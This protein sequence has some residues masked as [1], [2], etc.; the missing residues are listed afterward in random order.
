[1][2]CLPIPKILEAPA[3]PPVLGIEPIQALV[4]HEDFLNLTQPMRA[5]TAMPAMPERLIHQRQKRQ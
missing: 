5:S 1:M 3:R 2:R 4:R